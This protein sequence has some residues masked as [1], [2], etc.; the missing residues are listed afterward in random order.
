M[1][2]IVTIFFALSNFH[3]IF[4]FSYKDSL[5]YVYQYDRPILNV[6]VKLETTFKSSVLG[7]I[8]LPHLQFQVTGLYKYFSIVS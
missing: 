2:P 4:V 8:L 5:V 7:K 3:Y 1:S 6:Y